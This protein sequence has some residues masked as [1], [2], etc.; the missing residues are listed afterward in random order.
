MKRLSQIFAALAIVAGVALIPTTVF[1][2]ATNVTQQINGGTLTAAILDGSR[3]AV[4]SPSFTMSTT[5]F[6]FDCQTST[7]TLGTA[8]QRL[9]V[10]NPS[11]TSVAWALSMAA[12]GPWT[13]GGT[14][15]AYNDPAGT[16]AGCTNGQLTVNPTAGTLVDDC[17]STA[18]TTATV[19]VGSSTAMTGATAVTILSAGA[20]VDVYRGYIT[21]VSLS[22]KIPGETPAGA[23]SLPVTLTAAAS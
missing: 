17:V 7:G 19:N 18:C 8:G 21:G 4:V 14:T 1:G 20:G 16:E 9:Y 12:T 13:N 15:Y 6:S 2:Q 5:N 10:I 23:Y 11:G 22:Q 3:N